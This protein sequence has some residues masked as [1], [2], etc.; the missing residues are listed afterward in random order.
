MMSSGHVGL[1][2]AGLNMME[3][4]EEGIATGSSFS[5]RLSSAIQ[6]LACNSQLVNARFTV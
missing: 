6:F 3:R 1:L 5:P 2:T 4:K